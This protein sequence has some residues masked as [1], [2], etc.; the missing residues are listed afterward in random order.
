M[1]DVAE[2][3]LGVA[4]PH[5]DVSTPGDGPTSPAELVAAARSAERLGFTTGWVSDH[6][7]YDVS[8]Y[9]YPMGE[10]GAL[11]AWTAMT[12]VGCA[13]TTLHIGSLVLCEA[14]RPPGVLAKMAASFD[15]LT[16]G[17]LELGLGA[18]WFEPEYVRG[19]F[20]FGRPGERLARLEDYTQVVRGML[21]DSPYSYAGEHYFCTDAW[22]A[23]PPVQRPRPSIWIGG[24]GD[25][26]LGVVARVADGWNTC[27]RW[28]P[29]DYRGRLDVLARACDAVDRDPATVR[30]SLGLFC[31][32]GRSEADLQARYAALARELPPDTLP[33]LAEYRAGALVGTVD[34]VVDQLGTWRELGVEHVCVTPG[35][36]PFRWHSDEWAESVAELLLQR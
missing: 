10:T 16:D 21:S 32:V 3:S 9:G 1:S 12:L 5:Y 2:L 23:P 14:F 25:R 17:R 34:E 8:R 31:L 33:P 30:R 7:F 27:W 11:E 36:M 26:L 22:C 24:K 18:G 20:R 13:T 28:T 29:D 15:V 35:P 4:L 19:G 6:F